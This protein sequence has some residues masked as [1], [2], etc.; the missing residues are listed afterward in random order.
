MLS[1]ISQLVKWK[2]KSDEKVSSENQSLNFDQ[3]ESKTD[4]KEDLK[5]YFHPKF[6]VNNEMTDDDTKTTCERSFCRENS[7][8]EDENWFWFFTSIWIDEL[9]FNRDILFWISN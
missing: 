4:R 5:R 7:N 6:N 3:T 1:F 9:K 8:E 2:N